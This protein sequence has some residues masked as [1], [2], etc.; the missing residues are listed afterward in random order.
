MRSAF[1][2]LSLLALTAAGCSRSRKPASSVVAAGDKAII[3]PLV[4]SVIDSEVTQQLGEDPKSART[5]Q[6][7]FYLI[8][9]SVT[10]A[11]S[12]EQPIP[13]MTL[14]DDTGKSYTELTDGTGVTNWLGV[15]RR[16]GP[17]QTE[18]GVVLFDAPTKHYR[19]RLNDPSGRTR[20][21]H[22][23]TAEPRARAV[24]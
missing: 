11:S 7:R 18:Q 2:A 10:N 8:R 13:T 9:V 5:P 15:V 3:G 17:T 21:C 1:I 6:E 19:L 23:C 16:V 24:E 14:V 20:N 22:R 4:Y 12:D